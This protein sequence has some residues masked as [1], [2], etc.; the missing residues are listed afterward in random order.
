MAKA[1]KR[2]L[3]EVLGVDR[4]LVYSEKPAS[5]R[6]K[7]VLPWYLN[8][9]IVFPSGGGILALLI[10]SL[11]VGTRYQIERRRVKAYQLAAVEELNDARRVQMGL[12]PETLASHRGPGDRWQVSFCQ[13]RQW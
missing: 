4:D 10:F 13:H 7:V 1:G 2:D 11:A 12:M 8:G 5:V 9:W 3:Y 6:L